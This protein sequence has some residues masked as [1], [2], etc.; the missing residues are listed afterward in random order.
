MAPATTAQLKPLRRT[1]SRSAASSDAVQGARL[2][3]P[4][5]DNADDGR[6]KPPPPLPGLLPGLRLAAPALGVDAKL[7]DSTAPLKASWISTR[8]PYSSCSLSQWSCSA[9]S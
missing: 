4:G 1:C 2:G 7:E 5:L 9:C 3:V 8:R 6:L